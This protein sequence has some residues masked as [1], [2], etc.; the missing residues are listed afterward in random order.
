MAQ[1][2]VHNSLPILEEVVALTEAEEESVLAREVEKRRTRLDAANAGP[3]ALRKQVGLG[4]WSA[5]KVPNSS[6]R[7]T[8]SVF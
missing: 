6:I 7:I 5:S 8:Y 4:I 3:E 1:T 2:A